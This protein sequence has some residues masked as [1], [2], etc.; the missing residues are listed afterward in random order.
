MCSKINWW[1]ILTLAIFLS[2][3]PFLLYIAYIAM[4]L[5]LEVGLLAGTFFYLLLH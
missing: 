3:L 2:C 5:I 1:H 4:L